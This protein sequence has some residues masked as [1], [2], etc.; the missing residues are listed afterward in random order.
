MYNWSSIFDNPPCS[1]SRQSNALLLDTGVPEA[2]WFEANINV[3]TAPSVVLYHF[4]LTATL[5]IASGTTLAAVIGYPNSF[6]RWAVTCNM[7]KMSTGVF[8]LLTA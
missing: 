8:G 5:P 2:V 1:V 3:M 7:Y 6:P 4:L